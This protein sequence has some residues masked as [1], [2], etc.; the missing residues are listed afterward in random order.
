MYDR[1]SEVER[2][3]LYANAGKL[4]YAQCTQLTLINQ[5]CWK[6]K[7]WHLYLGTCL[8]GC[9]GVLYRIRICGR[10]GQKDLSKCVTRIQGDRFAD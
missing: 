9:N 4:I 2:K 7:G 3:C 10:E 5:A 1:R 6:D 8:V